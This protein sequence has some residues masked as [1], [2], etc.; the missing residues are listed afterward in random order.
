MARRRREH[1]PG[2]PPGTGDASGAVGL[3]QQLDR[4]GRRAGGR[5]LELGARG[6]SPGP[7]DGLQRRGL[8][9]REAQHRDVAAGV[10]EGGEQGAQPERL[11][12][13]V[14]DHDEGRASRQQWAGRRRWT[15]CAG[16]LRQMSGRSNH[17][18]SS[19]SGEGSARRGAAV[20]V[21]RAGAPARGSR[22]P[23]QVAASDGLRR[24]VVVGAG[25]PCGRSAS[26]RMSAA[27]AG[28]ARAAPVPPQPGA[29][30]EPVAGQERPAVA[31]D[32]VDGLDDVVDDGV[33]D[34]VVEV[35]ADPARA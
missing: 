32:D 3:V 34:E 16:H 24:P 9:A 7:L 23:R 13:R 4:R 27:V 17:S 15:V 19:K 22:G 1:R 25:R 8:A 21:A 26:Y 5:R 14:R 2:E 28:L 10:G 35:D 6:S 11:V 20:G 31:G 33:G 12:V 29:G 30:V 18:S